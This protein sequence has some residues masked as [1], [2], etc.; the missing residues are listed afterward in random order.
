VQR[1][2]EEDF[3]VRKYAGIGFVIFAMAATA[4]AQV[5]TQGNIF[6]GYSF[7]RTN[8]FAGNTVSLNGWEGSLEGKLLPW[9]GIVADFGG[10]YGSNNFIAVPCAI[11]AVNC[12]PSG[13]NVRRYTVLFGPRL[14]IPVGRYTP[15]AHFLIGVGHVNAQGATD[16]SFATAAGGGLD[17]RLIRGLAWRVQVDNV[18]TSFFGRGEDHIRFSTGINLRF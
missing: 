18:H 11:G 8:A 12:P 5:P 4:S 6:F 9:V 16:L 13:R 10:G 7:S 1:Q 17:Y 2:G 14:S 3:S 15:F